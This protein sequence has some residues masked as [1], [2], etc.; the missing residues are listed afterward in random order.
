VIIVVAMKMENEMKAI[1][2][3]EHQAVDKDK[4]LIVFE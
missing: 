1:N 2:M 3:K 4:V